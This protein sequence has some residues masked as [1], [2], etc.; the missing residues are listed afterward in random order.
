MAAFSSLMILFYGCSYLGMKLNWYGIL[1][2]PCVK[3]PGWMCQHTVCGA[4]RNGAVGIKN[5]E[6]GVR[7][8]IKEITWV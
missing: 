5:G 2:R 3:I 6:E 1:E 7:E 8:I 4:T